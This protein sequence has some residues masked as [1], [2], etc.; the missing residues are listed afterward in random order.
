M[1]RRRPRRTPRAAPRA[2]RARTGRSWPRPRPAPIRSS[3]PR[4]A[5]GASRSTGG[6]D[7]DASDRLAVGV[8]V[9][10][11]LVALAAEGELTDADATVAV[12]TLAEARGE[13][14]EAARF[15]LHRTASSSPLL[16][17][18]PPLVACEIQLRLLMWLGV[19]SEASLWRA[20]G[21]EPRA[22][23]V[24]RR[25]CREPPG[26]RD[27]QGCAPAR[28]LVAPAGRAHAPLRPRPA[29]QRPVRGRRRPG[30]R[31]PSP[32]LTHTS[33]RQQSRS[34]RSTSA[35]CSSSAPPSA[36]ASSCGPASSA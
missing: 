30:A 25:A 10:S 6:G 2:S 35:S 33:R 8:Y 24:A 36:S 18:L 34:R 19:A 13:P 29:L 7:N 32:R 3:S 28:Q 26:A 1:Q 9:A 20:D 17:E 16:I 22:R 23:A 12:Q 5:P 31:S 14:V 11:A 27:G 21:R 15:D 4:T